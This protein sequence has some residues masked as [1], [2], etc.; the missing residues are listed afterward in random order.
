M[1]NPSESTGLLSQ[2]FESEGD[3]SLS[4]DGDH[5]DPLASLMNID[6]NGGDEIA[7]IDIDEMKLVTHNDP[8]ISDLIEDVSKLRGSTRMMINR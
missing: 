6:S 5:S 7:P 2:P 8:T 4:S 3:G 1:K